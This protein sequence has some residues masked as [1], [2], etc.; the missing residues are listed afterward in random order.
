METRS[1]TSVGQWLAAAACIVWIATMAPI[2]PHVSP[3]QTPR[4]PG[5]E[6]DWRHV[7]MERAGDAGTRIGGM[8]WVAWAETTGV[9]ERAHGNPRFLPLS[10]RGWLTEAMVTGR[11]VGMLLAA[12]L[13]PVLVALGA[14]IIARRPLVPAVPVA[15]VWSV[16]LAGAAVS[17]TR[18]EPTWLLLPPYRPGSAQPSLS[19]WCPYS[20]HTRVSE[21][22]TVLMATAGMGAS[23]IGGYT[24][25]GGRCVPAAEVAAPSPREAAIARAMAALQGA[26]E[27]PATV[28]RSVELGGEMVDV[29]VA[30]DASVLLAIDVLSTPPTAGD[31]AGRRDRLAAAGVREYWRLLVHPNRD[32]LTSDELEWWRRDGQGR[33]LTLA[34]S[35]SYN[36][37]VA[38]RLA[39]MPGFRLPITRL[40]PIACTRPASTPDPAEPDTSFAFVVDGT[41]PAPELTFDDV[42]AQG[43]ARRA[44]LVATS[45]ATRLL[46]NADG[47]AIDVRPAYGGGVVFRTALPAGGAW[48]EDGGGWRYR[49]AAG[50]A[51]GIT[52]VTVRPL[53]DGRLAWRVEAARGKYRVAPADLTRWGN[54]GVRVGSPGEVNAGRGAALFFSTFGRAGCAWRTA[55]TLACRVSD[56]ADV[57]T[58]GGEATPDDVT[59]CLLRRLASAQVAFF[60]THGRYFTGPCPEL[61]DGTLPDG[62]TCILTGTPSSFSASA[63]HVLGTHR[64]GCTWRTPAPDGAT[65]LSCS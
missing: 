16:M 13:L 44:V 41:A 21:C 53:A 25:A 61:L 47:L 22:E 43:V 20:L 52:E 38:L 1:P 19:E 35:S 32:P 7:V 62:V 57:C 54:I 30:D 51:A 37:D 6:R 45:T 49:D 46:P 3:W 18:S 23:G 63:A 42:D 12:A 17:S 4:G 64:G 5:S 36:V 33:G 60:A 48:A 24:Y 29:V 15:L 31:D 34:G 58:T 28:R 10:A 40:L 14:W 50:E 26:V 9:S 65:E 56:V 39:A 27:S 11:L 55:T 59:R 8:A 2:V